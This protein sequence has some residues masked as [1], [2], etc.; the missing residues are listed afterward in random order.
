M[1][2]PKLYK[3][4]KLAISTTFILISLSSPILATEVTSPNYKIVGIT[5]NSGGG[6]GDSTNYSLMLIAGEVSANPSNYSTNYKMN[7]DPSANFVAAI[8]TI[9]CFETNTNGAATQCNSAP[10]AIVSGGMKAVCGPSGCYDRARFE[11]NPLSNPTDTLYAVEISIDNFVND[12]KCV[13]ASTFTPKDAKCNINDFRTE[14]Y[15]ET[16]TFN[17]KGLNANTTYYIRTTALHGDFTQSDYT[18]IWNATTS[19]A[20]VSFDI[21]IAE[22]TGTTAESASPYSISFTGDDVLI[23]GAAATT[24]TDLIW[25]DADSN[26]YGGV[27]IIQ[28]GRYGGLHSPTTSKTIVSSNGDLDTL[29]SEGF[30]LQSYYIGFTDVSSYTGT[31]TATSNYSGTGNVVGIVGQNAAKIY[32]ADGPLVNGRMGMYLKAKAGTEVTPATDYGE[33]IFFTIVPLY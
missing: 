15:W 13:S 19:P 5:A 32:E 25:L 6:L 31:L 29:G 21:D 30:G 9:Q 18:K 20:T 22:A 7:Q 1:N 27:S 8:P 28:F 23:A 3:T 14:N 2:L 17:I 4:I 10:S 11:I 33:E 16:E 24:N 12:I 26:A